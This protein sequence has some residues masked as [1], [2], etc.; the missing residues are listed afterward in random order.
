M[1]KMARFICLV[2]CLL[3]Q[4]GLIAQEKK[5]T[6][7]ILPSDN[8]C[9]QRF[10]SQSFEDFGQVVKS[11]DY[12]RAFQEDPEL[13]TAISQ[14]GLLFNDMGYNVKDS[15]QELKN[16]AIRAAENNETISKSGALIKES[17]IDF[18]KRSSKSDII[19]Q[20]GWQLDRDRCLSYTL[21]AF[22]AY[23]SKRIATAVGINS[24]SKPLIQELILLV[25]SEMPKFDEQLSR[26]FSGLKDNGREIVLNVQCWDSFEKDLDS[27]IEGVAILDHIQDWLSSNTVNGN[28][29][30]SDA[31]STFARFE[32]VMIPLLNDNGRSIDARSFTLGL[33]KYLMTSP[34]NIESRLT[35]RGLGEVTLILGER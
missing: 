1:R 6:I 35:M 29:N 17:P 4:I 11:P 32:Q 23:T 31:S 12:A 7:M 18:L 14:V 27:D 10:Y 3:F 16:I 33:R 9:F 22:D 8:W 30:L 28:F 24:S 34:F 13:G 21:D 26:Y 19:I 25:K 15:E 2:T 5:P 20:L